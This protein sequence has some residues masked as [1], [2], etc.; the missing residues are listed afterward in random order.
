MTTKV[1]L[2]SGHA[3]HGKDTIAQYAKEELE[4]QNKA[5]LIIHYG[6]LLK[7]ICKE[8]FGWDSRKDDYGRSLLQFIG[9][10]LVRKE[11]P[12]YWADFVRDFLEIFDGIWDY[13][14]IPDV[15]FPNEILEIV[16]KGFETLH[17]RV[18]RTNFEE[19]LSSAQRNHISETALDNVKPDYLVKNSGTLGE[20]NN[21]TVALVKEVLNV[22]A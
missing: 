20:L 7:H 6:D 12:N 18:E 5:V 8:Y 21:K 1:I 2:I 13:A 9:T 11:K 22:Q 3:R 15:R 10:D 16:N 17:I 19:E 4:K 14:I